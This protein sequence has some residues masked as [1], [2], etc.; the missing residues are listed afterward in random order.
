MKKLILFAAIL[1]AG[2]SVV[3]GQSADDNTTLNVKLSGLQAI[4]VKSDQKT[5]N[6]V[7]DTPDKY[8]Q[9]VSSLNEDHLNVFSTGAFQVTVHSADLKRNGGSETI[10]A[11]TIKIKAEVGSNNPLTGQTMADI[12]LANEPV[13]LIS[14][15]VGGFNKNFN[16]TYT[17]KGEDAYRT[18]YIAGG[19]NIYTTTVT[20]TITA[21]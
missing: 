18:D 9:G 8:L 5:V 3:N 15:E 11:S 19:E 13:N 4:T 2:V 6:L 14:S 12:A 7:Y 17:G 21:L 10:E 1:F 20:Y 16:I